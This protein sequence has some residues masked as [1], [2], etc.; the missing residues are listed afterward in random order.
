MADASSISSPAMA[1]ASS[2]L[3]EAPVRNSSCAAHL[4]DHM[5]MLFDT[6]VPTVQAPCMALLRWGC[7]AATNDF[8]QMRT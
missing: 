8:I 7:S 1:A 4:H 2:L 3:A 5:G 6:P